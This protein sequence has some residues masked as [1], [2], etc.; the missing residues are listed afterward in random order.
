MTQKPIPLTVPDEGQ[1]MS[2]HR[3]ARSKMRIKESRVLIEQ[4]NMTRLA[5][6]AI[7]QGKA[8]HRA[9]RAKEEDK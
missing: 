1:T 9:A 2:E 8:K 4:A 3:I 5:H 7:A 6:M